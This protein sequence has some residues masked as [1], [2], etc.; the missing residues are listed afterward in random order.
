MD[1]E[2]QKIKTELQKC[3]SKG[4]FD[5]WVYSIDFL[6]V[7]DDKLVL[8]CKNRLHM[9]WIRENLEKR[10]ILTACKHFPSVKRLELIIGGEE[11][12][13][14]EVIAAPGKMEA[15]R[16]T[17][18]Q[19]LISRPAPLFNP[20]FTFDDFVVGSCNQFAYAASMAIAGGA[21]FNDGSLF[22]SS[23][24]G[25]GKSHLSHAMGNYIVNRHPSA[26]VRYVTAEQFANEM[27]FSLKNDRIDSFKEKYRNDCDIL[28]MEK[29]E[30]LSGKEKVQS[31]LVYTFDEL[32]NRG[33]RIVCTANARPRDITR[34]NSDLQSRLGGILAAEIDRPD[35]KTRVAI[36]NHKI[37]RENIKMPK[38]VVELLADRVTGDIR[39]M[40][41]CLVGLMAKSNIMRVPITLSL[42]QEVT[43]TM[44][45]HIPK[46]TLENIQEVVCSSFQVS[47]ENLIS[48]SRRKEIAMARKIGMYLCR[49]YTSESLASI[50]RA[51]KRSHSTVLYAVNETNKAIKESNNNLKRQLDY[52]S[53]RLETSCLYS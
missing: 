29:I 23:P 26:R 11:T 46:L 21:Q 4:Q 42:A 27:I 36:I 16:Q 25:L 13:P 45:S 39:Q 30:F 35:F 22:L 15:P 5:L 18:F 12:A 24:T 7:Q 52:V 17:S 43:Q 34:L 41:S 20:R 14:V 37:R 44:L 9:G 19:E 31:E 40:E 47:I 3:I 10:L 53:Q 28:V 1:Q 51:F 33:K 8:G 50:G 32:M 49:Q 48:P 38:Q 6:G 2:W